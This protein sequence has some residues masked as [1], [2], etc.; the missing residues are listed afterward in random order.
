[1]EDPVDDVQQQLALLAQG[2]VARLPESVG[3]LRA[4]WDA[5]TAGA[6]SDVGEDS[7]G[8]DALAQMRHRAHK[9]SGSG[10]TFGLPQVSGAARDLEVYLDDVIDSGGGLG[11]EQRERIGQLLGALENAAQSAQ[12]D[13]P[14]A[15]PEAK[16]PAAGEVAYLD[17]RPMK[18]AERKERPVVFLVDDDLDV[19]QDLA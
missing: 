9:L 11:L 12:G 19:S 1:M 15:T 2:Y 5:A 14:K 3:A 4:A 10:A 8:G 6:V 7:R 18:E 16:D 17:A 13:T